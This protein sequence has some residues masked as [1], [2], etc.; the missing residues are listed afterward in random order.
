MEMI[1]DED[2]KDSS[3]YLVLK[4]ISHL[5]SSYF[6]RVRRQIP[7]IQNTMWQQI[8]PSPKEQQEEMFGFFLFVF[9]VL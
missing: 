9:K 7:N 5:F 4:C 8:P 6:Q 2:N 3:H 1:D